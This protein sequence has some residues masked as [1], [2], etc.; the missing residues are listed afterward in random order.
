MHLT[1]MSNAPYG[2]VEC[3]MWNVE[4]G[5]A[6]RATTCLAQHCRPFKVPKDPKVLKVLKDPKVPKV[7]KVPKDPKVLKDLKSRR[8]CL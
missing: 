6:G 2:N 1:V 8:I 7:L 5:C 3:G 4:L